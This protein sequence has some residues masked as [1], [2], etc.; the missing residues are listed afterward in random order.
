MRWRK[1]NQ[2]PPRARW[3]GEAPTLPWSFRASFLPRSRTTRSVS[4]KSWPY[5]RRTDTAPTRTS[6]HTPVPAAGSSCATS[7]PSARRLRRSSTGRLSPSPRRCPHSS[8][9]PSLPRRP[10]PRLTSPH[11]LS[12]PRATYCNQLTP[13]LPSFPLPLPPSSSPLAFSGRSR[14]EP[15]CSGSCDCG[16]SCGAHGRGAAAI[17]VGP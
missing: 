10:T 17:R 2:P 1:G 4:N 5:S 8:P 12:P 7:W 14:L 13:S 9:T 11:L 6:G 16:C 15:L 3:V